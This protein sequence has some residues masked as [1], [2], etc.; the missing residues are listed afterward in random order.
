[1]TTAWSCNAMANEWRPT[2]ALT[3]ELKVWALGS[4]LRAKSSP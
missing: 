1:M 4:I 2:Q 3:S